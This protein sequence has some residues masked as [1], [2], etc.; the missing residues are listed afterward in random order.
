MAPMTGTK[1]GRP[2]ADTEETTDDSGYAEASSGLRQRNS[3][4]KRPRLSKPDD[5][6]D[7]AS[8]QSSTLDDSG[9]EDV[10]MA[11]GPEE[12]SVNLE[13]SELDSEE[14]DND[15]ISDEEATRR[16]IEARRKRGNPQNHPALCAIIESVT[17]T[18]FM[19]HAHLSMS[20]GPLIN[21]IIGHN[22]SGKSAILAALTVCLGAKASANNRGKS[23]KE[24]IK[25]GSD[26]ATVQVK[27][28]NQGE[29][30]YMPELYG[31]SITVLRWFT[32]SGSSG[33]SLRNANGKQVSTKKSD[34]EDILSD[35]TL[36]LDN[37]LNVLTQDKAREFLNSS[38]PAEKYRF[39]IKGTHLERLDSDYKVLNDALDRNLSEL[40]DMRESRELLKKKVD[41]AAEKVK[42]AEETNKLHENAQYIRRQC[43]WSQVR[44][45][46][47]S[48][49]EA[50][51]EVREAEEFITSKEEQVQRCAAKYER[52]EQFRDA[53]ALE[54]QQ[55][56]E[57]MEPKNQEKAATEESF[58]ANKTELF[59]HQTQSRD[60]HT[61][62]TAS[63]RKVA[64]LRRQIEE[65]LE[66]RA[67]ADDGRHGELAAEIQAAEDE[68]V[69]LK[70]RQ[71]AHTGNRDQLQQAVFRAQNLAKQASEPVTDF[72]N[73]IRACEKTLNELTRSNGSW[74]DGFDRSLPA[75]LREIE[76]GRRQFAV[77]PVGPIGRHV[78]LLE[79]AWSS[80]LEKSFG[81]ALNGFI[82][83]SI[84][85]Q[86]TLTRMFRKVKYPGQVYTLTKTNPIDTS[87]NEPPQDYKTWLRVLKFDNEL[88]RNQ[89][90]IGQAIDQTVL[91][92]TQEEGAAIALMGQAEAHRQKIRQVFTLHGRNGGGIRFGWTQ[93]GNQ[94]QAPIERWSGR[95]RMQ[96]DKEARVAMERQ[97]LA[98]LKQDSAQAE[99]GHREARNRAHTAQQDL[100]RHDR[101]V[102]DF[103][104]QLQRQ[105]EKVNQ[106]KD[107]LE[108]ATPQTGLLDSYREELKS[109]E[110]D[111]EILSNQFQD[112]VIEK[113]KLNA[114]GRELKDKLNEIDKELEL[115]EQDVRNVQARHDDLERKRYN[116]L[117]EKNRAVQAAEDAQTRL[118]GLQNRRQELQDELQSATAQAG[119]HSERVPLDRGKSTKDFE[120]ALKVL[121][122]TIEDAK[123][124]NGGSRE[125]LVEH[126]ATKQAEFQ[127]VEAVYVE[128]GKTLDALAKTLKTRRI[129]WHKFR[130]YMSIGARNQFTYLLTERQFRGHLTLD[131][132]KKLLHMAI[133]PDKTKESGA[134]RKT[135]TLS[136]GEKSFSTICLLLS[137]WEAMGSPIRCLDEFDVFM[138]QVNR[139]VSMR[140]L[141]DTA[142][143]STSRQFVFITPQAMGSITSCDDVKIIKMSDPERGQTA[144]PFGS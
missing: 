79:A 135:T 50:D 132:D 71:Q 72:T 127:K 39:F 119:E 106:L 3:G 25:H 6:D 125:E 66:K 10:P 120:N 4:N 44:D 89:L 114:Q 118:R 100:V 95:P 49:S 61:E 115:A 11:G 23:L 101:A 32:M 92:A 85:D 76:Q 96:T 56:N 83:T 51:R 54:I 109:A 77:M 110:S 98:N 108:E 60:N 112:F 17:A 1:R 73:K 45:R 130:K 40:Y 7:D 133:E 141:I 140:M 5:A 18:N 26:R 9:D 19:C 107:Q 20:L 143:S 12:D 103:V 144:L 88:A 15:A 22:G 46:E 78:S 37:P 111:E 93:S 47:D 33:F 31:N 67:N 69:Q 91:A 80:V 27:I 139:D 13:E 8:V 138:D 126:H 123:K 105:E 102:R 57:A 29:L 34:L 97:N 113:R 116:L 87:G 121:L 84:D 136:G 43:I 16:Y 68:F 124:I 65:E 21:F 129:R 24:Y 82:V 128:L 122:K 30:A 142:R 41:K 38:T 81:G 62:L 86:R 131:H 117:L 35:L 70:E 74:Q 59:Q 36:Q 58:K 42:K 99:A 48:L 75:L 90:I 104:V 137:I 14:D 2:R 63:K 52:A 94:T 64:N 28:K 53:A 134:G 55:L